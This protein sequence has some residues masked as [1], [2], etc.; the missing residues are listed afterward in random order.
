M[1]TIQTEN[2]HTNGTSA[3]G[4]FAY[5]ANNA[6]TIQIDGRM[7][8]RGNYC[9]PATGRATA[10]PVEAADWQAACALMRDVD[11]ASEAYTET[12]RG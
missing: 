11:A 1:A 6:G 9:D 8:W 2:G 3:C 4:R 10:G 12:L 7:A 5:Q